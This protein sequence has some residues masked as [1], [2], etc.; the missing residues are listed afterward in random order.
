MP[1][2]EST[3]NRL[4]LRSGSTTLTL[5][6]DVGQAALQRKIVFWGLKPLQASLSQITDVTADMAVDR[7]SGVDIWHTMLV[8]DSGEAWAFPTADKQEAHDNIAAIRK[9]LNLP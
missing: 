7:A 3:P 2:T 1:V 9:F 8:F 6:K 4:V 5:D